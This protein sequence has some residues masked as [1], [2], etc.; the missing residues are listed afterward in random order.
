M[1]T[2]IHIEAQHEDRIAIR[3]ET[4]EA[5]VDALLTRET[6]GWTLRY[7]DQHGTRHEVDLSFRRM[8]W[9]TA[10]R[11]ALKYCEERLSSRAV[12]KSSPQ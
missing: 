8:P 7:L 2:R 5:R 9:P 12:G 3:L 10:L 4:D 6:S 1:P 11:L